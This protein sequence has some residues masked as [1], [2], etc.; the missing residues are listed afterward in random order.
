MTQYTLSHTG[1]D[2]SKDDN[3]GAQK[4]DRRS[5]SGGLKSTEMAL[6]YTKQQTRVTATEILQFGCWHDLAKKKRKKAKK[7]MQ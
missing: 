1:D 2:H 4:T 6:A 3:E 5:H 7:Q